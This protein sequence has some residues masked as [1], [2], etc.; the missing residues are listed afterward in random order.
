MNKKIEISVWLLC[1]LVI[2]FWFIG[3]TTQYQRP[4]KI[5]YIEVVKEVEVVV[6]DTIYVDKI[7]EEK[8]YVPKYITQIERDTI[9]VEV[10]KEVIVEKPVEIIKKV[11]VEKPIDRIVNVP[12]NERK[13]F[14]GFGYQYDLENY[15][16]GANIKLIHKTP[17]DKMF[18]LDVG[19]RN[20]LLDKETNV[21]RLRPY[22]GGSIY[23][24]I[25]NPN[26]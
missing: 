5:E 3:Y 14:L 17:K 23:F 13:L 6:T 24:R 19:F 16:S 10:I 7:I 20:D 21:G 15:F 18:S 4:A 2:G 26:K 8:I 22:I 25:D 1:L 11:Y 12:V 9:N